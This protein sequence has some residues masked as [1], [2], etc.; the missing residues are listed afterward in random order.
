MDDPDKML[1]DESERITQIEEVTS[2]INHVTNLFSAG[3]AY[4]FDPKKL[5]KNN[6]LLNVGGWKLSN[7]K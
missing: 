2:Q 7:R 5:T 6:G 3:G 1:K 4:S